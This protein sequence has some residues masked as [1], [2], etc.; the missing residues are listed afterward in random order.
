MIQYKIDL[1]SKTREPV[2]EEKCSFLASLRF[3]EFTFTQLVL[4]SMLPVGVDINV[5]HP[6]RSVIVMSQFSNISTPRLTYAEANV[7]F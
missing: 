1:F 5:R 7:A 4:E 3:E 6:G 2:A